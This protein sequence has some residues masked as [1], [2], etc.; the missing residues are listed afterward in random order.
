MSLL[1]ASLLEVRQQEIVSKML[2]VSSKICY[3]TWRKRSREIVWVH[4][5]LPH[6]QPQ[7]GVD[8]LGAHTP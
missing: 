7:R 3:H 2:V 5:A 1:L 4:L 6:T 8:P